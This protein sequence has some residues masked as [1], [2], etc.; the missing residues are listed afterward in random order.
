MRS[1]LK[2]PPLIDNYLSECNSWMLRLQTFIFI[3]I[4]IMHVIL[5]VF[6]KKRIKFKKCVVQGKKAKFFSRRFPA[7]KCDS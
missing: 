4:L 6:F 1:M 2:T 7:A 5:R 3:L